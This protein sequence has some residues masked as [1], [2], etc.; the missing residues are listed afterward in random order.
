MR[1]RTLK[2]ADIALALELRTAGVQYQHIAVGLGVCPKTLRAN[3]KHAEQNGYR[4]E[5]PAVCGRL[6]RAYV[7][8][9]AAEV[10]ANG[11]R[12][13][14]KMGAGLSGAVGA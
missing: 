9:R 4:K 8:S 3:L 6:R 10:L 5:A 11:A 12:K 1:F 2:N 13:V 7:N 14:S